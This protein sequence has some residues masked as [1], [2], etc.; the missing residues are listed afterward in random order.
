MM[1]SE[2]VSHLFGMRSV[3]TTFDRHTNAS[4]YNECFGRCSCRFGNGIVKHR[5]MIIENVRPRM[6]H[7]S[8]YFYC[9]SFLLSYFIVF[10]IFGRRSTVRWGRAAHN[11]VTICLPSVWNS[12]ER[13]RFFKRSF[14]CSMRLWKINDL[15]NSS[16][17]NL[18]AECHQQIA[19]QFCSKHSLLDHRFASF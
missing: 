9:I 8:F 6:L 15:R 4:A 5:I 16:T 17:R 18:L 3:F 2:I 14:K 11:L 12:P 10:V 19:E 13:F 7:L 1:T